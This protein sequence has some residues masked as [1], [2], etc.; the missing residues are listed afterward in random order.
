MKTAGAWPIRFPL[1]AHEAEA[2]ALYVGMNFAKDCCFTDIIVESDNL[3]V[4]NALKQRK[5][6]DS[7][8]G[9]F[10]ADALS[11]SRNFRSLSFTHVRRTGNRVAHELAQLALTNP[12]S[13]WME[14]APNHVLNLAYLDILAPSD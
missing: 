3:E 10:I 11:V 6:N 5:C 2:L 13:M 7:C 4:V 1:Q 12:I 9:T 14:D 8:F